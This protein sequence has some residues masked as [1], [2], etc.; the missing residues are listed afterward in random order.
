[1]GIN[2]GVELGHEA[3]TRKRGHEVKGGGD[4]MRETKLPVENPMG[5]QPRPW[6]CNP[7]HGN[8]YQDPP[9]FGGGQGPPPR[10]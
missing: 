2:N 10:F 3:T 8:R 1:M 6:E 7:S 4:V 9:V 5:T